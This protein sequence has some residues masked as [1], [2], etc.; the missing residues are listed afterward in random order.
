[1]I[2]WMCTYTK[3]SPYEQMAQSMHQTFSL[4]GI[5]VLC[6]PYEKTGSWMGNCLE[7]ARILWR[8]AQGNQDAIGILDADLVCIRTP[9]LLEH[10]P[11]HVDL[12]V[13]DRGPSSVTWNRY[14]AGIVAFGGTER[15]RATL[16][17]WA[18]LCELDPKPDQ[19]LREQAY[20]HEAIRTTNPIMLALPEEYNWIPRGT[21]IDE[22]RGIILHEPASRQTLTQMGG[23]R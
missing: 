19:R 21:P 7:R 4:N 14:S 2:R 1:M 8:E 5:S 16:R 12:M 15:G 22:E 13:Q 9:S 20:L 23:K 18:Q 10:M 17:A 3:D 6:V 11:F